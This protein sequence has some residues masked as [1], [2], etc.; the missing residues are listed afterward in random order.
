[1]PKKQDSPFENLKEGAFTRTAKNHGYDNVMVF[2]RLVMRENKKGKKTLPSGRRI[3]PL[4]V[5]R[6]N[7]AVNFGG[8]KK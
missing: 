7:F 8:K 1:M 3:T 4:M 6:A 2:A 5:K